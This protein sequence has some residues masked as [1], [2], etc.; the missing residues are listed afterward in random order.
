MKTNISIKIIATSFASIALVL[1]AV[2]AL[3]GHAVLGGF[4]IFLSVAAFVSGLLLR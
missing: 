4:L 2:S 3:L 1:G